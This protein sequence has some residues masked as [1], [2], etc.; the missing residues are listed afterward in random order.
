MGASNYSGLAIPKPPPRWMAKAKKVAEDKKAER[1][2]Y[3]QVDRRDSHC[4]R[5]C[6]KRVGGIGMLAAVHHHHIVYRSKGGDHD[7]SNVVSLCV[8]C[9]GAVHN[10]EIRLTGDADARNSIGV[11]CGLTLERAGDGGWLVEGHR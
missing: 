1:E 9:H 5:V 2:C 3:A 7:T 10:G 4:C 6:R 11:L 8:T